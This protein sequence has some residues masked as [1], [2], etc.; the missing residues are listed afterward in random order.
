MSALCSLFLLPLSIPLSPPHHPFLVRSCR[1]PVPPRCKML[2]SIPV[3]FLLPPSHPTMLFPRPR[4]AAVQDPITPLPLPLPP[5]PSLA[6]LASLA[7]PCLDA[8]P[9]AVPRDAPMTSLPGGAGAGCVPPSCAH[10]RGTRARTPRNA[11]SPQVSIPN[12]SRLRIPQSSKCY[13]TLWVRQVQPEEDCFVD[14]KIPT[15]LQPLK[16]AFM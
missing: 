2:P 14:N 4:A 5:Q 6:S 16:A 12:G 9:C 10:N 7:F 3:P 1:G 11:T 13:R 15:L 8:V